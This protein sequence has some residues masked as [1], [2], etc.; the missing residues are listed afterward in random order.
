[1]DSFETY[2]VNRYFKDFDQFKK[3]FVASGNILVSYDYGQA[4]KVHELSL[5]CKRFRS[6]LKKKSVWYEACMGPVF[7]FVDCGLF[8]RHLRISKNDRL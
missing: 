3:S 6:L 4:R 8:H 1:M 2:Y 7:S 5:V